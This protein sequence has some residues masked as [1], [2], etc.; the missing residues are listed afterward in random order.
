MDLKLL[1]EIGLT[2]GETKVY[3]SLLELG[4]TSTGPL[5]KKSGVSASKT[6]II[7]DKLSKKG[8]VGQVSKGGTKYFQAT[9]PKRL[10]DY[11]DEKEKELAEK[12]KRITALLPELELKLSL[13]AEKRSAEIYNGRKGI[14][15]LYM[16][17][18]DELKSGDHYYV[19][20]AGY[21]FHDVVGLKSWFQ[22]YHSERAQKNIKV[23][24]LANHSIRG[25]LVPATTKVSEIRYLPEE[26]ITNVQIAFYKEKSFIILWSKDPLGFLIHNA[27][28]VQGFHAYFQFLWMK[29]TN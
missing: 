24:M 17:I 25:Q 4:T 23:F 9:E 5:V 11:M 20:G 12:R 10:L 22:K 7:L 21:G 8:L 28:I 27:E 1:E 18:L 15:N 6:Y 13:G 29:A 2:E 26:L 16:N 19:L 14:K 3:L